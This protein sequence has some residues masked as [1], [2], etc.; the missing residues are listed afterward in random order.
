MGLMLG[1]IMVVLVTLGVVLW[2]KRDWFKK[3]SDVNILACSTTQRVDHVNPT[4]QAVN[5]GKPIF[6]ILP[7]KKDKMVF[8]AL[9][10]QMPMSAW[11]HGGQGARMMI[12]GQTFEP[13]AL[14]ALGLGPTGTLETQIAENKFA[15]YAKPAPFTLL[16]PKWK[17]N[18][19]AVVS[20]LYVVPKEL[21]PT[22]KATFA[23]H[24]RSVVFP[25]R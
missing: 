9:D 24:E 14:K 10:V 18:D 1:L 8:V 12:S 21:I 11:A 23:C 7:D 3:A 25:I 6:E 22:E 20:F 16:P 17:P 15:D 5:G 19:P 2:M 4:L 13:V